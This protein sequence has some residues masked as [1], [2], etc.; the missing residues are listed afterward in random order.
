[1]LPSVPLRF[2][3]QKQA[4]KRVQRAAGPWPLTWEGAGRALKEGSCWAGAAGGCQAA[5]GLAA[6]GWA[7][8]AGATAALGKGA[9]GSEGCEEVHDMLGTAQLRLRTQQQ[10]RN[11]LELQR[12]SPVF[13][14]ARHLCSPASVQ[15]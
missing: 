14:A 13:G 8:G 7:A 4:W 2:T 10:Y 1:L 5:A 15:A 9:R 11:C 3:W 6:R 12:A